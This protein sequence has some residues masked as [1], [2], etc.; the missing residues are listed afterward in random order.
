VIKLSQTVS[1]EMVLEKLIDTLMRT[2]I[3]QAGTN[4]NDDVL[5]ERSSLTC[6][7]DVCASGFPYCRVRYL[8]SVTIC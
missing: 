7:V 1:S 4:R 3:E 6:Q 2:A 8:T 5:P